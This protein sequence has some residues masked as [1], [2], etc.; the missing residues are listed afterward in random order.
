MRKGTF[1]LG[2]GL[3]VVQMGKSALSPTDLMHYHSG[4]TDAVLLLPI[5]ACFVTTDTEQCFQRMDCVTPIKLFKNTQGLG[6][7]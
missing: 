3:N 1:L 6:C 2:A 7:I 4:L 5:H